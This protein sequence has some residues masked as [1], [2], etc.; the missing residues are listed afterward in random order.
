MRRFAVAALALP[1]LLVAPALPARAD[2]PDAPACRAQVIPFSP[3]FTAVVTIDNTT[4]TPTSGWTIGF[5]LPAAATVTT[6][7]N[8]ALTRAGDHGTLTPLAWS[9]V[10]L[11][12]HQM[13]VGLGGSVTPFAPPESFTLNGLPCPVQ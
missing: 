3:G 12:G 1:A 2:V 10:I 13:F 9:A 4:S 7:F 8:G 6:V 11:P 5:T